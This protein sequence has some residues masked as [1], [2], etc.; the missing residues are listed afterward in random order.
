MAEDRV[1]SGW[2]ICHSGIH[3]NGGCWLLRKGKLTE[4]S[5]A[6]SYIYRGTKTGL[7]MYGRRAIT[8]HRWTPCGHRASHWDYQ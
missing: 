4:F 2:W 1:V 3:G 7:Y 8:S 5:Y 6:R